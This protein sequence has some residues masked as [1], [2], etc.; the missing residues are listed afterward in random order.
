[1]D[2]GR[3]LDPECEA[4]YHRIQLGIARPSESKSASRQAPTIHRAYYC[5]RINVHPGSP[6]DEKPY[7]L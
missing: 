3:A 6:F 1:M 7:K 4:P 2:A 5:A